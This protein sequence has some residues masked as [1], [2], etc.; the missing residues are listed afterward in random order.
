MVAQSP[1][2]PHTHQVGRV[3]LA[4]VLG[5]LFLLRVVQ[6]V[7]ESPIKYNIASVAGVVQLVGCDVVVEHL[8]DERGFSCW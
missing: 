6:C 8:S 5:A 3:L 4:V 2:P 7:D 1:H